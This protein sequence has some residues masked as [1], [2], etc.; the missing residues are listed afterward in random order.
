VDPG[1]IVKWFCPGNVI[2]H[3]FVYSKKGE[4]VL[5]Q[6]KVQVVIVNQSTSEKSENSGVGD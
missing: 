1:A 4:K 3:E 5:A 2:G 6:E